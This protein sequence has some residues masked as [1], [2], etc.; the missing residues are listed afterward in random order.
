MFKPGHTLV[1]LCGLY[2]RIIHWLRQFQEDVYN[3]QTKKSAYCRYQLSTRSGIQSM[4][5]LLA[6]KTGTINMV[7]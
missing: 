5:G 6:A 3:I 4:R 2:A 7:L 1:S